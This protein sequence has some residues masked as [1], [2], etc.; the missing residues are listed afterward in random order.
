[1]DAGLRG[2]TAL[3]TGGSSGIGRGIA[4][5]LADEGVDVAVAS[6]APDPA[7]LDEI[8]SRGVRCLR[9]Q[10]DVSR[11][12]ETVRMVR[13]A[14][15]GL[16]RIDLYVNNAAWAWHQ[17]FTRIDSRSWY[18]TIDTNLSACVWACREVCRHMIGRR[19][20]S[21]LIVGSTS[22]FTIS[23]RETAYRVSKTGLRVLVENLSGEMAPYGIRVNMV[24]PGHFRTRLTGSVPRSIEEKM[25]ALIP[26]HRFGQPENIGR[27][28][29][30]LLSDALSPYTYGADLVVDGGLSL[31]PLPLLSEEEAYTLNL[32]SEEAP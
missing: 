19:R 9:I 25:L 30:F 16:G 15:D 5:A 28:A 18:A 17:P 29:V 14:I 31:R 22:R 21:I 10:A 26:S 4:L 3:V 8:R 2:R 23:Y 20:G 11:E 12:D 27:A 32:D 13:E 7:A 1:M 24:T 6:R